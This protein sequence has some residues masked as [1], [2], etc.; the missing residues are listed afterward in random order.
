VSRESR[1]AELLPPTQDVDIIS[2]EIFTYM[3]SLKFFKCPVDEN[4]VLI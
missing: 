3:E 4:V 2:R 1:D